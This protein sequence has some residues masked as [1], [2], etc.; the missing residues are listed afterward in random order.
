MSNCLNELNMWQEWRKHNSEEDQTQEL[1]KNETRMR[2]NTQKNKNRSGT[3]EPVM[4]SRS[5]RIL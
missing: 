3:S 1:K 2:I 5:W 4:V